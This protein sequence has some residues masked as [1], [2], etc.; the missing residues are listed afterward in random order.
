MGG[1]RVGCMMGGCKV[2][3][4]ITACECGGMRYQQSLGEYA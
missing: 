2:S 4:G 1:R 3:V